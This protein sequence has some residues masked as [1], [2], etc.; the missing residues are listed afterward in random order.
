MILKIVFEVS[1]GCTVQVADHLLTHE[2]SM[3][4]LMQHNFNKI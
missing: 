2:R 4:G 3:L 1:V